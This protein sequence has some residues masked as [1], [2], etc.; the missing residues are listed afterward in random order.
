M[1]D[2][3]ILRFSGIVFGTL[4]LIYTFY[5]LRSH[6]TQRNWDILF[7]STGILLISISFFPTIINFP[8][9]LLNLQSVKGGRL[10]TILIIVS[11][12][13]WIFIG[14]M[15]RDF[16]NLEQQLDILVR[17]ITL[18]KA[19]SSEREHNNEAIAILIPALNESENL[20]EVL[21]R[22][23]KEICGHPVIT[24]VIDDASSDNTAKTSRKAGAVVLTH[25][26][27]RGGGAALRAGYDYAQAID[28]SIVVTMDADG[29]H[30]PEEIETL[31]T[32][33]IENKADIVIGSRLL[34]VYEK[35]SLVR[36][37]GVHFFNNIIS[38][39][40]GTK[41]TDCSS[42]FRALKL[43]K[44]T[45]LR[46]VQDQFHTAEL[47]IDAAKSGLLITEQPITILRR[48]HGHSKKGKNI[49]YGYNFLKTI[50]R[51]WFR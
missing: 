49:S 36:F 2:L 11:A 37:I 18:E 26:H 35:D 43:S 27:N 39:L 24:I 30:Q 28:S 21:P 44:L 46:L 17:N 47:I 40:I 1:N 42:G 32:P 20:K 4:F 51:T 41:V 48:M 14:K 33:I 8:T 13:M 9:D 15:K 22:I 23:P 12:I 19:L 6:S 16:A 34:G 50:V 25:F 10:I 5:K 45:Q 3:S 29:Q 38:F 7:G 31:V